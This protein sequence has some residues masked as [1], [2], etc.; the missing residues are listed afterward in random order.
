MVFTTLTFLLFLPL[1]FAVY[2]TL[3]SRAAQNA[4]LVVASYC[5]YGWWDWRF[6]G[7]MLAS[8]AVDYFVGLG[9]HHT[10]KQGPR[11]ALLGL[12]LAVNLGM[13]GFF[14]YCDFF[15]ESFASA[16]A[17]VGYGPSWTTLNIV[18]PVGISFYTFQTLSYSID[19]YRRRIPHTH[20]PVAFAAFVSF[21]PQ[22]VAGPIERA[23]DLLPQFTQPR[24]FELDLARQGCRLMLWGF[25]MKMVLADNLGAVVDPAYSDVANA[26]GPGLVIATVCF[27]F[28]IL[29]DFGGY[30]LI[31]IGTARLFGIRLSRNFAHPYLA[32]DVAE[33]WRRWHIT[34]STWF[35]DYVYIPLGGSKGTRLRRSINIMITFALSGLWHGASWNFV[36]WGLLNGLGILPVVLMQKSKRPAHAT[37][38]GS[39]TLPDLPTLLRILG[40]F[41]FICGTWV[42]FRAATL[43]DALS[44]WGKVVGEVLDVGA[45]RSAWRAF[46]NSTI[47]WVLPVALGYYIIANWF[48][49]ADP[50]E[51]QLGGWSLPL[52]WSYY[53]VLVFCI[54]V[55]G[56]TGSVGFI[57]FQ[58]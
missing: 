18:L 52:R 44:V 16:A 21:F 54:V 6:C 19:R 33:F 29:C 55:Y 8:T 10:E 40:T 42:F 38:G 36:I 51:M 34:L 1:V 5:F 24:R 2:W 13:L 57:Y 23:G 20:D 25:F 47:G 17:S 15:I 58:F 50:E 27:A 14:K 53:T 9:L 22:L 45:W 43:D 4:V 30:S 26:T 39:R 11:R 28:Q 46:A 32:Q 41:A 3:R 49:R 56:T 7:L 37:P 12:S 48:S 35:R 31:A